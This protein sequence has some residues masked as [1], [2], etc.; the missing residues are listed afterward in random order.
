MHSLDAKMMH[1]TE[2]SKLYKP[3]LD[4][5]TYLNSFLN[6]LPREDEK[7]HLLYSLQYGKLN[8][9]H[10]LLPNNLLI[11]GRVLADF[12]Q[13]ENLIGL[14]AS[15]N[16]SNKYKLTLRLSKNLAAIQEMRKALVEEQAKLN[17]IDFLEEFSSDGSDEFW[18]LEGINK[19]ILALIENDESTTQ[20][21]KNKIK[22][23]IAS[24]FL[25]KLDGEWLEKLQEN[26]GAFY[27]V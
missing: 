10:Y 13:E 4:Q 15:L 26:L 5:A 9:R 17:H 19:E 24:A 27:E 3:M 1:F 18:Q 8:L 7:L 20:D 6:L 16:K 12:W 14:L 2:V 21:E 25:D 23:L 22:Y 11:K